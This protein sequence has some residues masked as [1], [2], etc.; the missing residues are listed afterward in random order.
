MSAA[1]VFPNS[2]RALR[3]VVVIDSLAT[4]KPAILAQKNPVA[5]IFAIG[6]IFENM[7]K[8]TQGRGAL[9]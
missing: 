6:D 2:L 5:I 4:W 8:S 7:S 1:S 3:A 9:G